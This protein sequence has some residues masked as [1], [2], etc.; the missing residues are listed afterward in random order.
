MSSSRSG[1]LP[2]IHRDGRTSFSGPLQ[3]GYVTFLVCN[4]NLA[5]S[6]TPEFEFV[7][8]F[9]LRIM[10]ISSTAEAVTSDPTVRVQNA[11]TDLVAAVT[12]TTGVTTHTLVAAQQNVAKDAL[13]NVLLSADSGDTA[14]GT[15]VTITAYSRGHVFTDEAND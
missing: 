8:P 3:G 9:D 13:I 12:I 6:E 7:A 2:D 10:K 1:T 5:N 15:C 11:G 4:D 14:T